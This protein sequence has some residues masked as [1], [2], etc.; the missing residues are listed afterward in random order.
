MQLHELIGEVPAERGA[1]VHD[2]HADGAGPRAELALEGLHAIPY[3]QLLESERLAE[4][5]GYP[6]DVNPLDHSVA[7][8]GYRILSH[9]PRLPDP[10]VKKV[11]ADLGDLE[12]IV[13]ASQRDLEGSA[14]SAASARARSAKASAACRST[15]SSIGICSYRVT[16][17]VR[18]II[19]IQAQTFEDIDHVELPA[20]PSPATR[21]RQRSERASS[22]VPSRCRPRASTPA[23]SSASSPSCLAV[24]QGR[25]AGA[26]CPAGSGKPWLA[27]N[28]AR[29]MAISSVFW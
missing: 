2:Y 16:R 26:L 21:S 9:I 20:A 11:V 3:R 19:S 24:P 27:G 4:L 12:A 29:N 28:F 10:V 5:L 17:Q 6:R 1:V 25:P 14:A 23:R 15:T 7:P 18:Y 8:R 13:R 22:R